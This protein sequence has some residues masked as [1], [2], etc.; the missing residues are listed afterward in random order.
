MREGL[1]YARS[2]PDLWVPLVMMARRRHVRLQLPGRLPA[3]RHP[4][5]R[6]HATRRSPSLFSVVSVGSLVG[7]LATARRKTIDVRVG[8]RSPRSPSARRSALMAFAPNAGGRL[9]RR[10]ARR[11]RQHR[12]PDRV[13]GDRADPVGPEMRGRVLAL[14]AM[15]FLGSTPIGGPILGW[16]CEQFGARVTASPSVPSPRSAPGCGA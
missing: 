7:A 11:L 13:D 16:I 10:A 6:R 9:P 14:Q 4:R 5:P 3:V 12:V 8:R 15:V 1:R 2:V